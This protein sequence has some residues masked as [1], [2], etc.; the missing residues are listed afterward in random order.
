MSAFEAVIGLEV[1]AQLL[2]RT[3]LFCGC[4]N[5]FG[6]EANTHVCPVCLGLP[7]SLPVINGEAVRLA[8]LAALALDCK[9]EQKSQFAR[10]QYFYPDLP[11]G[12]Q[13]SQFEE[14]YCLKGKLK[15]EVEGGEREIGITRIHME[16]DAGKSMH[17]VGGDSLVDLNRAGTPLIEIV[18]EPE[19]RSSSEAAA[20]LR[21]LR[22]ILIFLGVNDG[23]LEEGSF[24]CDANVSI[25]PRGARTLGTR[26]ELKNLNSFR[27]VQRAIDEE[28]ARQTAVVSS[29]GKVVQ[30]TRSF[31]P[32]TNTTRSLRSKEESHDYRYF[33]DPDLPPLVLSE[34]RVS[35][36]EASLPEL[37]RA[38]RERWVRD[39]KLSEQA[40]QTLSSHP[41]Y[42]R[43][44]SDCLALGGAP[45]KLANWIL[46]E[47]LRGAT[48]RGLEVDFLVTPQQVA[49]TL[50]LV[51]SGELSGKQAKELHAALEGSQKSAAE[52]V[53]EKGM[54]QVSDT[55]ALREIVDAVLAKSQKQVEQYRSGKTGVLGFFVGQVMKE[56]RGQANPK[57]V[58]ELLEKAL[59]GDGNE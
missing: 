48:Q 39:F 54:R 20:Y 25:R 26:T 13:I 23:N 8:L 1:H 30:E 9:V 56:T 34:A 2:T 43:F 16:E 32:D 57:L 11:K 29:G 22:N 44:F 42:A 5:R 35:E 31:D 19:L 52:V 4:P 21:E 51:E 24:R 36:A 14:P 28:I 47:V 58:S 41:A 37:P 6:A 7:G 27:F 12:Y 15:I 59:S 40:A 55:G 38:L 3:K 49:D 33:P 10:K 53:S 17:G 50:A 45:A 46:T 18:S